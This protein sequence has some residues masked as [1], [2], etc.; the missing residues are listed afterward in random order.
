[1]TQRHSDD[2]WVG[3]DVLKAKPKM[4]AESDQRVALS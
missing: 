3:R 4:L 1:M 2:S